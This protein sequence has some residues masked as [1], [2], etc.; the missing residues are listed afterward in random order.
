MAR[1]A[2]P[3]NVKL[4]MSPSSRI[5]LDQKY[6]A[7]T[8]LGL[9]W[10]GFIEVQDAY[11]WDPA[12]QLEGIGEA[13][14]LGVEAPLWTETIAT[15]EELDYMAFPRLLGVAEIGWS[16]AAG[17]SWDE[18]RV[19]LAAHGPRLAAMGVAFYRSPQVAWE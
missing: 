10:A 4:I 11:A 14:I 9:A 7:T 19:R 6:S 5:Y 2:V 3:Q 12:T 13:D 15:P 16:P 17:R 8:P 18:Y 1:E